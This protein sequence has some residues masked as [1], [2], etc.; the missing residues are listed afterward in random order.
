MDDTQF[1]VEIQNG[2]DEVFQ[3]DC[4]LVFLEEAVFFC[5]LEQVSLV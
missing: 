5:V 1:L 2:I 3:N 4:C